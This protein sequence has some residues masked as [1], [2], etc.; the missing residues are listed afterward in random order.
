MNNIW[1][2]KREINDFKKRK[3][4]RHALLQK[5]IDDPIASSIFWDTKLNN[6]WHLEKYK[7]IFISRVVIG[8]NLKPDPDPN[9]FTLNIFEPWT[10]PDYVKFDCAF[11][12]KFII[13][14]NGTEELWDTE[15]DTLKCGVVSQLFDDLHPVNNLDPYVEIA[16][17]LADE[18][19]IH[20][21]KEILSDLKLL[22]GNDIYQYNYYINSFELGELEK[23]DEDSFSLFDKRPLYVKCAK[24]VVLRS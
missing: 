12:N 13:D 5:V 17:V 18:A 2:Q 16:Y 11:D 1:L 14:D 9:A 7:H 22:R 20:I 15:Y 6:L 21:R 23:K 10:L 8:L 4:Y 19:V 24:A 3:E